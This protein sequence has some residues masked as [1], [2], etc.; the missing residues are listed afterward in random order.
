MSK[1]SSLLDFVGG[2]AKDAFVGGVNGLVK[3]ATKRGSDGVKRSLKKALT[4]NL[5]ES[6]GLGIGGSTNKSWPPWFNQILSLDGIVVP[7][8]GARD[9]GKTTAQIVI[10]EHIQRRA[11]VPIYFIGYP[12]R[13]APP[14]ITPVPIRSLSNVL[15]NA[16]S[17]S[18]IILDDA[19]RFFSSKRTMTRGGLEFEDWINSAAHSGHRLL[20]SVQ[21]SSD[22]HKAG[23]RA[24]VFVFKP[25]ERMFEGSERSQMRPIVKRALQAFDGIPRADWVKHAWLYRDPDRNGMITYDRPGWMTRS[26][27][28]YR[29]R[30]PGAGQ[31]QFGSESTDKPQPN[32]FSSAGVGHDENPFGS[33]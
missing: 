19:Y 2:M 24:D 15:N 22:L 27:A 25:P 33:G 26:K 28:K 18:V 30:R 11:N 10:A 8:I 20:I 14:H 7:V 9:T 17:G 1:N 4:E 21:D 3:E 13:L 32:P 29:G 12:E 5:A 6:S 23:L 31:R 16:E